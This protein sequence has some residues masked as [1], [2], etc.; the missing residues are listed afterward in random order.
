MSTPTVAPSRALP[1][2]A[3]AI[4][5]LLSACNS[6][7]GPAGTQATSSDA[8][9]RA[10]LTDGGHDFEEAPFFATLCIPHATSIV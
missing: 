7:E 6:S 5:H 4:G 9:I 8:P 3:F 2:R 1:A 10:L